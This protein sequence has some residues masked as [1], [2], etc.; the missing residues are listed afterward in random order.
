MYPSDLNDG[1]WA[2]LEPFFARA[3]ALGRPEVHPRRR[4]VEAIL[5]RLR[6][7]CRWRALPRDFPPWSTVSWHFQRWSRQGI[8]Q[9][10]VGALTRA[11]RQ[12]AL[13]RPRR[14]PRHAI[15]DSQS[16]KSAAEGEARG[17]HGGKKIKGRSRH[18]VVDSRGTLLALRVTA[19]SRADSLEA[20]ATMAQAKE[21]FA[22]LESFTA[23]AAYQAQAQHAARELLGCD[24]VTAKKSRVRRVSR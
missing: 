7:G 12:Q 10:A 6:E 19:A 24:L 13:G 4:I 3:G 9:D 17:F 21:R 5:Y 16:V 11:E 18:A 23:D 8:L 2:I 1:Q 20:G 14:L 22:S 15:I